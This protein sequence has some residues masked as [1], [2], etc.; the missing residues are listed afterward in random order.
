MGDNANIKKEWHNTEVGEGYASRGVIRQA[1]AV[2][3]PIKVVDMRGPP[4]DGPALKKLKS[5][6]K[7]KR[8]KK[9]RKKEQKNKFIKKIR[10]TSVDIGRIERI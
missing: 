2:Y 10:R 3:D 1:C 8:D 5:E 9:D 4:N 6:K 7:E